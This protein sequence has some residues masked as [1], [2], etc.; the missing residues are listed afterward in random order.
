MYPQRYDMI[1]Y[2]AR[3]RPGAEVPARVVAPYFPRA[4]DHFCGHTPTPRPPT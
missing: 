2:G 3:P 4:W 1:R